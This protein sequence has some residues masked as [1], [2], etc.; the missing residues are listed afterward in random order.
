MHPDD[1]LDGLV[2]DVLNDLGM[3]LNIDGSDDEGNDYLSDLVAA[4]TP[5]L[6]RE[7]DLIDALTEQLRV[8]H[9]V[10]NI[11]AAERDEARAEVERTRH[12]VDARTERI[13]QLAAERDRL[14]EE[15]EKLR[16]VRDAVMAEITSGHLYDPSVA[17][18]DTL[19]AVTQ[20]GTDR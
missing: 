3:H 5:L 18:W 9:E 1:H 11:C 19:R 13:R 20:E 2:T 14:A 16:A 8:A 17:L 10:G 7:V 12:E 15:N 4:I 6:R